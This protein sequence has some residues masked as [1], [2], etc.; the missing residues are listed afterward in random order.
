MPWIEEILCAA[1][2][3]LNK[4]AF[5]PQIEEIICVNKFLR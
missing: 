4:G 3:V 1:Q 5:M 2:I